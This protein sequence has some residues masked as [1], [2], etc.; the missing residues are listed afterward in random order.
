M[1]SCELEIEEDKSEIMREVTDKEGNTKEVSYVPRRF[2]HQY[3]FEM[4]IRVRHPYFETM[5]FRL[6]E[7]TL[8]LERSENRRGAMLQHGS[9][10]MDPTQNITYRKY[11]SMGEEIREILTG[12][13]ETESVSQE[14]PAADPKV[15]PCCN[16]P[17]EGGKFCPYCGTP[18]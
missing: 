4:L 16:A 3:D 5:R 17:N 9:A 15:C 8:E 10:M 7:N 2:L 14:A 12:V 1:L 6:N 18:R 11:V 13:C